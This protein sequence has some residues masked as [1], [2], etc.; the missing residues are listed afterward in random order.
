MVKILDKEIPNQLKE[1]TVQQFE[2]ITSVHAQQDL[3]AI[4]KHLK[5]FE[6]FGLTENDFENTTIEQF[7]MYVKEFNNIKGK[8]E[9]QSSIEM[10]GYKYTA[11]EGEEFKLSVKDTKHIEKVMNSRHKG[12]ISEMLAILFKRDDLTKT[13]HYDSAHIK[14]KAKQIREFKAELAVPFL[15]E[16]GQKLSKEM[17]RNEA[18]EVVE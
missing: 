9:L 10:D 5:V 11:F 12:Y 3:D 18:P 8:P 7:K 14:H 6:L 17:K 4:E 15:V 2:D 13:E 16:I 1:L